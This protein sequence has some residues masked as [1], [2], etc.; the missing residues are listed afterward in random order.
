[1]LWF[2]KQKLFH[3]N[4]WPRYILDLKSDSFQFVFI[5][6]DDEHAGLK[7]ATV[8]SGKRKTSEINVAIYVFM[9][10]LYKIMMWHNVDF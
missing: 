5:Y 1:M 7:A 3:L 9:Q 8:T 10:T 4:C 2:F 6:F